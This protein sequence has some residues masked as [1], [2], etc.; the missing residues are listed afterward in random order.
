MAFLLICIASNAQ[1]I[2]I[3]GNN[4]TD[5]DTFTVFDRSRIGT[6]TEVSFGSG[7]YT[8]PDYTGYY[9]GTLSG[10][11]NDKLETATWSKIFSD[12][13]GE[14]YTPTDWT[15]IDAFETSNVGL[16]ISYDSANSDGDVW[17]GTW[18]T[19]DPLSGVAFYSI[20]AA[21]EFA[22]YYVNPAQQ[23][24]NWTTAHLLTPNKKSQPGVSHFS[25]D[26]VPVAP[27]PEPATMLLLGTGLLGLALVG[28]KKIIR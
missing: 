28:K 14:T 11:S 22:L 20:K 6:D 3:I 13:L 4:Y 9:F 15:K 23:S 5:K 8:G 21:N 17:T 10:G 25:A 26:I 7:D 24:G 27:V 1:A 2:S 12:Y 16:T 18:A 19:I